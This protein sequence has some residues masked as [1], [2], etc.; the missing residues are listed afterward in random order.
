MSG[1]FKAYFKNHM[2]FLIDA[3][4]KGR[5]RLVLFD[6]KI[7]KEVIRKKESFEIWEEI[8]AFLIKEK[9]EPKKLRGIAVLEGG[10][11]TSSRL[12]AVA[13]NAFVFIWKIPAIS[14]TADDSLEKI[15]AKLEKAAKEKKHWLKPV[16]SGEP[17]IGKISP[18][19][20]C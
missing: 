7:R 20:L 8:N 10:T 19:K 4:E 14:V 15:G 16:Y 11:F 6:A 18:V 13:A 9:I 2:Y 17:R 5:I 3:T 12:A 1:R